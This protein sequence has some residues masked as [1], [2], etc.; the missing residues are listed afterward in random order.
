MYK[1]MFKFVKDTLKASG[2]EQC[3]RHY[4]FRRRSEHIRRVFTWAQRLLAETDAKINHE[5]VLAAAL[6]HDVGH[7]AEDRLHAEEGA[8]ICKKYLSEQGFEENFIEFVVY[9][10]KNHANKNLLFQEGTPLELI[11]L[12]E[13]DLLDE[14]GALSLV[15][16][17]MAEGAQQDQSFEKALARIKTYSARILES[18]P[19][20]TPAA[21]RFWMAKQA[22]VEDFVEHLCF[23][24][25][26]L[27]ALVVEEK[28]KRARERLKL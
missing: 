28:H 26:G 23:D 17:S 12:M 3:P 7:G 24:L 4:A 13:A 14:T 22:L 21:K 5:A 16:D 20:R 8:A 18:N 1:Q 27:N 9:L 10:V 19:M 2:G 25:A 11:I 6:F 15:W